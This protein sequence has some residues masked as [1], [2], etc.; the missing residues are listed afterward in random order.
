[1]RFDIEQCERFRDRIEPIRPSDQIRC[2][3]EKRR[4]GRGGGEERGVWLI[5]GTKDAGNGLRVSGNGN[6]MVRVIQPPFSEGT[7]K[8]VSKTRRKLGSWVCFS[9]EFF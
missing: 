7:D 6:G 9:R 3:R 4:E 2:E 1:M 8:F 5:G